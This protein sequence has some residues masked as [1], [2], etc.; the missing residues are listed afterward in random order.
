[1]AAT[2][3]GQTLAVSYYIYRMNWKLCSYLTIIG[4]LVCV[5]F[6]CKKNTAFSS[7]EQA[8]F[9]SASNVQSNDQARITS[10]I[11]AIFNDV[12]SVMINQKAV[13]GAGVGPVTR[14]GVTVTGGPIDTV[15]TALCNALVQVDAVDTPHYIS[16]SYGGNVC[17]NSRIFVGLVTIYFSPGTSWS[18]AKDTIGVNLKNLYVKGLQTDTSTILY[19]GT[20]YYTNVSGG[21]LSSLT[22]TASTSIVHAIRGVNITAFFNNL[23]TATWQI[24]RKRTYTYNNGLVITTTGTDTAGG[25]QNV[26]EYGGNRYGNSFITSVDTPLVNTAACDFQVTKGQIHLTNP[27]GVTTMIF[28]LNAS[29]TATGCPTSGSSYHYQLQSTGEGEAN[30]S[31]VRAYPYHN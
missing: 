14:Q 11:D 23:T 6:A 17:D 15:E 18:T 8:Q 22:S 30:Y 16:I 7:N 10:D 21:S 3:E 2:A 19:N 27:S 1:M 31:A 29:G 25:Q 5:L 9:D 4:V 28:G 26:S 12:N 24:A 20:F 13:T